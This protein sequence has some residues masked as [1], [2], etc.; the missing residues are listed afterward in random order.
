M[1]TTLRPPPAVPLP[2]R[3]ELAAPVS[4]HLAALQKFLL[5]QTVAFEGEIHPQVAYCLQGGGK[6]IR[7]LLVFFAGWKE[8]GPVEADLVKAAAVVELVHLATLVHDD[9]L[10][11]ASIRHN[12]PTVAR[13]FGA[14]VAVLLGD[15]LFA[16]ALRL[17]SDFPT[18]T[19]CR[20]VSEATRRVCTGEII[21]TFQRGNTRLNRDVYYRIID[22]KTAELFRLSAQLGALLA[23]YP[24]DFVEAAGAVG[25]R[26]GRAFQ[27]CDDVA[28]LFAAE[29]QTGKTLGTD[30]ANGKLTLPLLTLLEQADDHSSRELRQCLLDRQASPAQWRTLL[31]QSTVV[32]GMR[33][34]LE[35]ELTQARAALD[36][37]LDLPPTPHLLSISRYL[38][39]QFQRY[40]TE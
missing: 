10:D 4:T 21:Q 11:G 13:T 16:H 7:P 23:D 29:D 18:V 5:D 2:N 36:P 31:R 9:I 20:L 39:G 12:H 8:S 17:A 3:E 34:A 32:Q 24:P 30:L 1:D 33:N 27:M 19:V 6:R 28:D 22:L 25:R 38:E 40:F 26:L 37:Y 14:D 35:A 15:A